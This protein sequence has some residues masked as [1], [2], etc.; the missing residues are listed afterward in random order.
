MTTMMKSKSL[1]INTVCSLVLQALDYF[2]EVG[3]VGETFIFLEGLASSKGSLG[4]V[5]SPCF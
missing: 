4:D 2:R 1:S 5:T 3:F